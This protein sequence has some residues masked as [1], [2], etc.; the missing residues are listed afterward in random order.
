MRR[1]FFSSSSVQTQD[2]WNYGA[3]NEMKVVRN[4]Y[5]HEDRDITNAI[6]VT[7][8]IASVSALCKISMGQVM[9]NDRL[10]V[11]LEAR[12]QPSKLPMGR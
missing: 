10:Y 5:R 11:I 7:S 1:T 9:Q 4:C 2:G 8:T 6:L 12:G 3:F